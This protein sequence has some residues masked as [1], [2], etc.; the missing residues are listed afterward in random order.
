MP[1]SV[2]SFKSKISFRSVPKGKHGILL[3]STVKMQ[4]LGGN[5]LYARTL[6]RAFIAHSGL[7]DTQSRD[8]KA[9]IFPHQYKY[10]RKIPQFSIK[11]TAE[12]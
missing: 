6:F 10:L 3:K 12:S 5:K 2:Q 11:T 1:F 7:H 4:Y 9:R 8:L